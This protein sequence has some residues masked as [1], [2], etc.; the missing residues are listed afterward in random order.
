MLVFFLFLLSL[1][2]IAR[3][4]LDLLLEAIKEDETTTKLLES[5][6]F[7]N[8]STQAESLPADQRRD[9]IRNCM[10]TVIQ[11]FSE[12]QL[13]QLADRLDLKTFDPKAVKT[14]RS[15]RE[16]LGERLREGLYGREEVA[17]GRLQKFRD[18]KQVNHDIFFQ[19]Y[20]I[21]F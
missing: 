1:Q 6:G 16:Y 11:G 18:K 2:A 21:R 8:C 20:K 12:E 17:E 4:E 7:S 10:A 19:L 14:S 3:E 9:S 13:Q 15:L 5:E